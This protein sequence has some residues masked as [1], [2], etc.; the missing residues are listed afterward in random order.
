MGLLAPATDPPG[1]EVGS[2]WYDR[3]YRTVPE[4]HEHYSRSRYYF[5]WT[6]IAD[7]VCRGRSRVVLEVGCGPGHLAALLLD[8]GLEGYVGFDFSPQA[9]AM[10]KANAPRGRFEVGDARTTRLLDRTE[11]DTVICTEVLEHIDDDLGVLSRFRSGVRCLC[12]VP[13]FPYESHVRH[14]ES[15]TE[16]EARY[17]PYFR[18]FDVTTF[19]SPRSGDERYYLLDGVRPGQDG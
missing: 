11:F 1:R 4:Y 2:D 3:A 8:R 9:I 18:D 6:V 19:L 12:T 13:S 14:F 17:G 16:V 7:R 15:A 5:L 10:A